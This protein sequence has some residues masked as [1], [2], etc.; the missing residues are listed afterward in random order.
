M[1][2]KINLAG[3]SISSF[4]VPGQDNKM[5]T[6]VQKM[7]A[8][9]LP[10]PLILFLSLHIFS[11]VLCMVKRQESKRLDEKVNSKALS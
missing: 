1:L 11:S 4:L 5:P 10:F 7:Y 8:S 3:I 6:Q 2:V 9:L